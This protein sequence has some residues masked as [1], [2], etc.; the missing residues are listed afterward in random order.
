M[1]PRYESA[2]L[3]AIFSDR[4]RMRLWRDIE[5]AVVRALADTGELDAAEVAPLFEREVI[6]DDDFVERVLAREAITNHDLA[7]FVDVLQASY[8]TA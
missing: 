6:V 2:E 5:L 4:N 8:T 1:I 3:T 7:A